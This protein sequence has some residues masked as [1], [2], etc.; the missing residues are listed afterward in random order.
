MTQYT[1][2]PD[3]ENHA[4]P[5]ELHLEGFAAIEC[6][7]DTA[8][9]IDGYQPVQRCDMCF[10]LYGQPADL[11][12]NEAAGLVGRARGTDTFI[13]DQWYVKK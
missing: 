6:L 8:E 4:M 5:G 9:E 7:R 11:D 10:Y 3:C 12:D 2:H 1:A 13:G